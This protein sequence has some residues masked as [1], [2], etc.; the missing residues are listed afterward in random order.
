MRNRQI[1]CFIFNERG[2]REKRVN[3]IKTAGQR[4]HLQHLPRLEIIRRGQHSDNRRRHHR[5]HI[6]ADDIRRDEI[7]GDFGVR[8]L[9]IFLLR[10]VIHAG[11][12]PDAAERTQHEKIEHERKPETHAVQPDIGERGQ[13]LQQIAV[14]AVHERRAQG[15]RNERQAEFQHRRQQGKPDAQAVLPE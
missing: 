15:V 11:S 5:Q 7:G 10:H 4:N 9:G 13:F 1:P 14:N 3:R 8:L 2:G 12:V 6:L